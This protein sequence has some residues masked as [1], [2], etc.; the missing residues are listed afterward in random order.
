MVLCHIGAHLSLWPMIVNIDNI[1]GNEKTIFA[2]DNVK[3][4]YTQD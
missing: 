2:K 1:G 3:V 4:T